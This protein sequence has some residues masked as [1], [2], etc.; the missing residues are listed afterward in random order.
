[1]NLE[2]C[3]F[4]TQRLRVRGWHDSGLSDEALATNVA[5]ILTAPVTAPLPRDWHGSYGPDRARAWIADRDREGTTLLVVDRARERPIGLLILFGSQ[6]RG[7]EDATEVR[8]GYLLAE[9]AWGQGYASE[10]VAGLVRRCRAVGGIA[11][12]EAGVAPDNA[13][14]ARVLTKNGFAP[15]TTTSA[16]DQYRLDLDS[17]ARWPDSADR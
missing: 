15:L 13:A 10:L 1:M 6:P 14:S 4:E 11:A 12:L 7:A 3:A 8:L 16:E 5:G 9:E 2:R 17:A